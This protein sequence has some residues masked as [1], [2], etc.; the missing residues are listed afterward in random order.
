[1]LK[2]ARLSADRDRKN[3]G[4]Q[5]GQMAVKEAKK[6]GGGAGAEAPAYRQMTSDNATFPADDFLFSADCLRHRRSFS[7]RKPFVT[8]TH[9]TG[10][11]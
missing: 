6:E 2:V 3:E 1:M 5:H 11:F 7:E 9:D 10:S 4:R 8:T